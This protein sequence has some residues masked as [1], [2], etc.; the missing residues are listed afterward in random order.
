MDLEKALRI[1]LSGKST[2]S[3]IKNSLD[4]LHHDFSSKSGVYAGDL[5]FEKGMDTENGWIVSP[6]MAAHCLIDIERTTR[7]LRAIH[8]AIEYYLKNHQQIRILYAGCGP[9]ATLLTPF[10]TLYTPEQLRFTFLEINEESV[11]AVKK[12]HRAYDLNSFIDDVMLADATNP[13]LKFGNPFHIIVSETMQMALRK[14][15]QVPITRN[16]V[17]FLTPDGTFIPKRIS[18]DVYLTGSLD[19]LNPRDQKKEYVG[20][21]YELDF[22]NV[23]EPNHKTVLTVPPSELVHLQLFTEIYLYGEEK[24]TLRQ[25]GLTQPLTLDRFKNKRPSAVQFTYMEGLRPELVFK[26]IV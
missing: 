11:G 4:F 12:L 13:D 14:E 17:K 20:T 9:Y 8:K 15:C 2:Y 19:P 18:L 22:R 7:F 24:L 6:V 10:T 21:A 5:T 23:P 25:S 3:S 26:Y 1:I 16:L